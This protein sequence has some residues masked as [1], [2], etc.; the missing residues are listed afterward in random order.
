MTFVSNRASASPRRL[1]ERVSS[2]QFVYNTITQDILSFYSSFLPIHLYEW[3]PH[4]HPQRK[5]VTINFLKLES[6]A[7][8]H[9]AS[10]STSYL[11]NVATVNF[12]SARSISTS[13]LTS[14]RNMTR[15]DIIESRP[16]V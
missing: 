4:P 12:R 1:R 15:A 11:S 9:H 2:L 16:T 6:S 13:M 5:I 14:V 8:I 10:S 7:H 3:L